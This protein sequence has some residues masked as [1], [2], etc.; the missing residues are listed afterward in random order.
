MNKEQ[1]EMLTTKEVA[2]LL[3]ISTRTV[4][5]LATKEKLPGAIKVGRQWRFSREKLEEFHRGM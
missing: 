1:K 2:D 3:R 4:V 5:R